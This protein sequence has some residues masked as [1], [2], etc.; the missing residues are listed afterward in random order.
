VTAFVIY[1][2]GLAPVFTLATDLVVGSAPPERAGAASA[3]SETCSEFGG[4][5][6]IAILGSI[7]AAMYRG[8]MADAVPPGI[9]G[10]ALEAAR[11][12]LGAA[13]AASRELTDTLGAA[14]LETARGA[15]VQGLQLAAVISAVVMIGM[16]IL[17]A[18]TFGRAHAGSGTDEPSS[19]VANHP[20]H[21]SSVGGPH[22]G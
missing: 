5:L 19:G 1:S 22:E 13:V 10:E 7:G 2:L 15:F 6:G 20:T 16:A 21:T 11:N 12:T 4:A 9:P 17:A 3:I 18:L 8:T 14:L